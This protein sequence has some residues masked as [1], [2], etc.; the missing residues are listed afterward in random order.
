MLVTLGDDVLAPAGER[1]VPEGQPAPFEVTEIRLPSGGRWIA[2]RHELERFG[3][4]LWVTEPYDAAFAPV[5][6]MIRRVWA[7]NLAIVF[8]LGAVA[9]AIARSMAR[10][11]HE[12]S[13][14]AQAIAAGAEDVD[15]PVVERGDEVGVLSRALREMTARL[16]RDHDELQRANEILTQLSVTDGLTGLH[17]HRA[18]QD[19]LAK[20][21]R[22]ANRTG[23]PL[24]LVLLDVDDFKRLNDRHGHATGDRVLAAVGA[25]L[26]GAV[27]ETDFAARYG[28]EEFA[29]LAPIDADGA[30]TLAENLRRTVGETKVEAEDG[31]SLRVTASAGFAELATDGDALFVAAD[32]ALYRA[33][34]AGKDCALGDVE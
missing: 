25:A 6:G 5:V 24:S 10:P 4:S 29:V 16:A 27:R 2:S 21:V 33:K 26:N 31:A 28:G 8:V 1:E 34:Q 22:R 9:F 15:I 18:F 30:R 19:R 17:N 11:I 32:R 13:R 3:W 14:A 12:L 7:V 20:E 23:G